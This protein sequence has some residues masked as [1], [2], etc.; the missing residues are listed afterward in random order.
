MVFF[1]GF[2]DSASILNYL[3]SDWVKV[4]SCFLRIN[5]S[6]ALQFF[7]FNRKYGMRGC[8]LGYEIAIVG[9]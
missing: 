9:G 1:E 8:T 4:V 6:S 5:V 2:L 3:F 7:V